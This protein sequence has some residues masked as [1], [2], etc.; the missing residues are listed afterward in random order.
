SISRLAHEHLPKV[1]GTIIDMGTTVIKVLDSL[2]VQI[3]KIL[4]G[5][6]GKVS[7][8]GAGGAAG[9][10]KAGSFFGGKFV[11]GFS[12]ALE[13]AKGVLAASSAPNRVSGAISGGI[14]GAVSGAMIGAMFGP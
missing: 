13:G 5:V 14:S 11:E 8:G 9:A 2:G 10:S 4:E 1:V 6:F 3:P 12:L 7:S